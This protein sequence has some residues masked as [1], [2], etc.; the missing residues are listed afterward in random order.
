MIQNEANPRAAEAKLPPV[1]V[2][3]KVE[4]ETYARFEQA[5]LAWEKKVGVAPELE[6]VMSFVLQL[7]DPNEA[8]DVADQMALDFLLNREAL[9]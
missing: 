5:R 2:T 4:A 1:E 8:V 9:A 6:W 7:A 3:L